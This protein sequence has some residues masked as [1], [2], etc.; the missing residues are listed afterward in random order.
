MEL[1]EIVSFNLVYPT[2]GWT[3]T[4]VIS[5]GVENFQG[6]RIVF[7]QISHAGFVRRNLLYDFFSSGKIARNHNIGIFFSRLLT[8]SPNIFFFHF[9]QPHNC[10]NGLSLIGNGSYEEALS[11]VSCSKQVSLRKMNN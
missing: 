10:S 6:A 9:T 11:P 3:I 7:V 2:K 4:K 8:I 1:K 5:V